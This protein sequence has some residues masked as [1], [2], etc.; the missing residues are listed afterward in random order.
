MRNAW[1]VAAFDIAAPLA[2][3]AALIYIGIALAWPLW[4]VSLCS[5]LCLLIVEGVIVNVVSA[6][7]DAV[8]VGTDDDGPG[9]RLGVVAVATA[10]VAA[11]VLVGYLKWTVP[12]RTLRND[13]ADVVGIASSVAEASATF[14]PQNPTASID[15]AAALMAPDRAEAFKN[16]FTAV[17]RDL[18]SRKVSAQAST[19]SAGVE[20]IGPGA[21]S[22][23]VILHAT[24]NSPGKP[25]DTAVLALRV[26]LAKSDGRWLVEDVSPIH[27]R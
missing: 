2:A 12:D 20:A 26:T 24:Q 23:A 19:V 27:S 13:S 16:E 17:A 15:R 9:L 1:R 8:T 25:S 10:A 7:R 18:T 14:T 4:W 5:V 21:A 11:A 6:R 22:V 3:I